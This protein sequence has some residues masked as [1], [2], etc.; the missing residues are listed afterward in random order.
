MDGS[1]RRD[2]L[3]RRDSGEKNPYQSE[4]GK[5]ELGRSGEKEGGGSYGTH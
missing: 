1:W 2:E 4:F 3:K 5:K